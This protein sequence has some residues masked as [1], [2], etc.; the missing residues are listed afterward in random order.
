MKFMITRTS[1]YFHAVTNPQDHLPCEGARIDSCKQSRLDGYYGDRY[2]DVAYA[3]DVESIEDL[4][5]L[6]K[7]CGHHI[8]LD[9][10]DDGTP[11]LEIY[12][13]WRE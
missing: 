13:D 4:V 12:D 8:I 10:E 2:Y 9:V 5:A 1:D 11:S 6:V 3:I 7:T